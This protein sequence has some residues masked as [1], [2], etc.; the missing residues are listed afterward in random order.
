M[1]MGQVCDPNGRWYL[2]DNNLDPGDLLLL[3]GKALQQ[4]T[5]GLRRA[6]VYRVVPVAATAMPSYLGRYVLLLLHLYQG[7]VCKIDC[8][9]Q[10]YHMVVLDSCSFV[11]SLSR[12]ILGHQLIALIFRMC[13]SCMDNVMCD[14]QNIAGIP[15][16]APTWCEYWLL[17][18]IRSWPCYSWGIWTHFCA[19][20]PG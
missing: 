13:S 7:S 14:Y 3:T 4:A 5:A 9:S 16:D 11:E 10:H 17:C 19:S 8:G 1:Y 2:A 12:E 18:N 6:C 20:V 15:V